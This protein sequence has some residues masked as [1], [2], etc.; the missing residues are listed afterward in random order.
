MSNWTAFIERIAILALVLLT[1]TR[2]VYEFRLPGMRLLKMR[3]TAISIC[4]FI[5]AVATLYSAFIR[6]GGEVPS[7]FTT[8]LISNIV[9]VVLFIAT[10]MF[11]RVYYAKTIE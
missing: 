11:Y 4:L 8:G 7:S 1:L 6:L 3:L 5:Y 9:G 10:L 2:Q